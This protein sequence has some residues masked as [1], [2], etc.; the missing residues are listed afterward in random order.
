[1]II[2]EQLNNDFPPSVSLSSP[3][4]SFLAVF[5]WVQL[6]SVDCTHPLL[7]LFH[8][9][10]T[11]ISITSV[12]GTTDLASWSAERASAAPNLI[13]TAAVVKN[14]VLHLPLNLLRR[15]I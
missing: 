8:Y 3:L 9:V 11:R 13:R 5:V 12:K 4:R 2:H 10:A 7:P 1:M 14:F 15:K 6:L